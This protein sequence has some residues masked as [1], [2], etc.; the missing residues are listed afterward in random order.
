LA[1][2]E[3]CLLFGSVK[4]ISLITLG[5]LYFFT[6]LCVYV[7]KRDDLDLYVYERRRKEERERE[8]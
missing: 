3:M 8:G 4:P 2:E 6:L 5:V 1:D 7:K